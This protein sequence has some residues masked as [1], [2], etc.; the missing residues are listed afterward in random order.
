MT[1][2]YWMFY[3]CK[4]LNGKVGWVNTSSSN[5]YF[6]YYFMSYSRAILAARS[7]STAAL[8]LLVIASS[9]ASASCSFFSNSASSAS[10]FATF[11]LWERKNINVITVPWYE[12]GELWGVVFSLLLLR[13]SS[14]ILHFT[15][16]TWLH[17]ICELLCSYFWNNIGT[18]QFINNKI[19]CFK[20]SNTRAHKSLEVM[21]LKWNEIYLRPFDEEESRSI[22]RTTSH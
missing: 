8:T 21:H 12:Y 15:S 20:N 7:S 14:K 3:K 9:L 13:S 19:Y 4:V 11:L 2:I 1:F 16:N 22:E 5:K 18:V 6:L 17:E 10:Y